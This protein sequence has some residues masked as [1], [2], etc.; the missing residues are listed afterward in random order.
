MTEK[1]CVPNHGKPY[2]LADL[3]IEF[4]K[5]RDIDTGGNGPI[6]SPTLAGMNGGQYLHVTTFPMKFETPW[7]KDFIFNRD[8]TGSLSQKGFPKTFTS[9]EQTLNELLGFLGNSLVEMRVQGSPER[10]R[11]MLFESLMAPPI[12][13]GGQDGAGE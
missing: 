9:W 10:I 8:G 3:V 6:I 13:D 2:A 4:S 7:K 1:I 5:I 12:T 11:G